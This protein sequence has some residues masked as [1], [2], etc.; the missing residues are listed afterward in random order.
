MSIAK[1]TISPRHG[2]S[3]LEGVGFDQQPATYFWHP[4]S[5]H[6]PVKDRQSSTFVSYFFMRLIF[7]NG[8]II[9]DFSKT[10]LSR[11]LFLLRINKS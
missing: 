8:Q 2:D 6:N 11:L 10:T 5:T 1:L 3:P 9:R 7:S 4:V